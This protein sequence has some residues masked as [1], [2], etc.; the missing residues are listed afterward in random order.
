MGLTSAKGGLMLQHFNH[1]FVITSE[2]WY[3]E[4][5]QRIHEIPFSDETE[6]G[7]ISFVGRQYDSE[8]LS[9]ELSFSVN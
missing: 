7:K 1:R 3:L 8:K 2:R 6:D 4:I 9:L 5:F